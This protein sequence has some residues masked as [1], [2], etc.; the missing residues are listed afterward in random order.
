MNNCLTTINYPNS[1]KF[2]IFFNVSSILTCSTKKNKGQ[3]T[4]QC[5]EK[6]TWCL[7]SHCQSF[8]GVET[9]IWKGKGHTG[10][11]IWHAFIWEDYFSTESAFVALVSAAGT[12]T[13]LYNC[14][15]IVL[16]TLS[17]YLLLIFIYICFLIK[18]MQ[19][20]MEKSV[21]S[22]FTN[23]TQESVWNC[24]FRNIIV[25]SLSSETMGSFV[26]LK[27]A[28]RNARRAIRST[29]GLQ[30]RWLIEERITGRARFQLN[31]AESNCIKS[32]LR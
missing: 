3:R 30:V 16:V 17:F 5:S 19:I 14:T 31:S 24:I 15:N 25:Y 2:I 32:T 28:M 20:D 22:N 13:C 21:K 27:V 8:Q 26:F 12:E 1:C 4:F 7:L 6:P 10:Y 23:L 11:S 29:F 18:C 9:E